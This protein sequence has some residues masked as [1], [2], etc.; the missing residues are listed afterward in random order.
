MSRHWYKDRSREQAMEGLA[1]PGLAGNGSSSS[2]LM[3]NLN[4]AR[5]QTPKPQA[6]ALHLAATHRA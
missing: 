3:S 2:R 5:I 1:H 4:L 6:H